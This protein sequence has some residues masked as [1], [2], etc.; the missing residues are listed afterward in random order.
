MEI[1]FEAGRALSVLAFLS[2]GALCLWT[3]HMAGEFERFGLAGLRTLTGALELLGALG[4]IA[5][6]FVPE[7][8]AAASGGLA[9][10]M[11]LGVG[12]RIRVRDS[13]VSLLPALALFALNAFLC[14]LTLSD[15][16]TVT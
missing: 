11:L 5:G 15:R 4:L 3:Q 14:A 7:L 2:Y 9:L 13:F 6:Y 1:L 16:E 8:T 10:L 12:A